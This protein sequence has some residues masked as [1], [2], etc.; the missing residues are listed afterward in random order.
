MSDVGR[1]AFWDRAC[2]AKGHTGYEDALL[3]R[4]DQ[5][6][7]LALVGRILK[8]LFPAGMQGR[9]TLDIGCGSGDFIALQRSHQAR[10]TGADI[11]P[12]VIRNTARRFAG[13]HQVALLTGTILD[14]SLP[15]E[16]FD[17][18]TSVT[19]LQHIVAPGEFIRSLQALASSLRA[20][21]HM[22]VLELAPPH[23]APV[24]ITDSRG[25]AYLLERP[26]A[27]WQAAFEQAG[28]RVIDTPVF[29]Q[30]GIA[31]LRGLGWM[32][33]RART[34]AA[35]GGSNPSPAG[36]AIEPAAAAPSGMRRRLL[37]AGLQAIRRMLLLLAR[38]FDHLF[39]LPLPPARFRH[40]RA[41]VL[42]RQR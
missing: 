14:L 2:E 4:Y 31:L 8:R 30:L 17:V 6:L 9:S 27:H 1:A 25:Y 37:R 20:D 15:Q 11:S 33:D 5:P 19:V 40:Y 39:R 10:V 32:I 41:W 18:I 26:P 21:G 36:T 3:H 29:P 35:G 13:D 38:P 12:A 22:I 34:A 16:A 23:P 24:Q 28:L 42:V 7:R